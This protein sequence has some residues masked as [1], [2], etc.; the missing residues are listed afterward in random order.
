[1]TEEN[2]DLA[3]EDTGEGTASSNAKGRRAFINL[4]RELSDEE[5]SSPAVQR[6]LVDEI[7][8][9][10]QDN[11]RLSKFQDLYYEADRESAVLREKLKINLSQEVI[12]GVCLTV[13]AALISFA[14]LLWKHEPLGWISIALGVILIIGG[15]ASKV[16]KR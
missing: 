5:L 4:R 15:V 12:F 13:G 8:R 16:V 10:E 2:E 6:M 7:E 3:P 11:I 9:I 1:M 14:P